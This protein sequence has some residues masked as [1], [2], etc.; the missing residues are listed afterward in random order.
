[1]AMHGPCH[2]GPGFGI[3]LAATGTEDT[4]AKQ[5]LESALRESGAVLVR[6][7]KHLVYRLPN[8]QKVVVSATHSDWRSEMNTVRDIRRALTLPSHTEDSTT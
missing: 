6:S 4:L 3:L 5:S 2:L 7:K 8:G 1:M